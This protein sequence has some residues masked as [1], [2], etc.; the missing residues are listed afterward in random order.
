MDEATAEHK[1]VAQNNDL[2]PEG[3][4]AQAAMASAG[5]TNDVDMKENP[6]SGEPN[7]NMQMNAWR[8]DDAQLARKL[9]QLIG[10][11]FDVADFTEVNSE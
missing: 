7:G 10:F 3:G 5:G 1:P 4:E 11:H 9:G 2:E 6:E 8:I